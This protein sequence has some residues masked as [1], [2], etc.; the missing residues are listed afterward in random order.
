MSRDCTRFSMI[1]RL[2]RRLCVSPRN[3]PLRPRIR[4]ERIVYEKTF[5]RISQAVLGDIEEYV[6]YLGEVT[7][8]KVT[9]DEIV[10]RGMQQLF[11]TDRGFRQWQ[12][13]KATQ[14]GNR[15]GNKRED[16]SV[17]QAEAG[18]VFEPEREIFPD[19]VVQ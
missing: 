13:K 18:I 19:R 14:Q 15:E 4:I 7:Q 9:P 16:Q 12:K 10:D 11:A 8:D 5:F 2:L 6:A 3:N 17:K 1:K